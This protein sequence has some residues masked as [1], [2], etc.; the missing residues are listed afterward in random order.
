MSVSAPQCCCLA[1][2]PWGQRAE[3]KWM[4]TALVSAQFGQ[5][6]ARNSLFA[7]AC[8]QAGWAQLERMARECP[9][10]GPECCVAT[11]VCFG[12]SVYTHCVGSHSHGLGLSHQFCHYRLALSTPRASAYLF[13]LE[14]HVFYVL[15]STYT[16]L[17][18]CSS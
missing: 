14:L 12:C 4:L 15:S 1:W 5:P 16:S 2:K 6:A 18:F 11:S 9:L 17:S 8:A 10:W 7:L 3:K 13:I